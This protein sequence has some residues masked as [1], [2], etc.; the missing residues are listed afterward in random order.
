MNYSKK[1]IIFDAV[2]VIGVFA[3]TLYA[4]FHGQDLSLMLT[5]IRSADLRFL[6][7][8]VICVILF[9]CLESVVMHILLR[10]I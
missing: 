3:L 2:F 1:R 5:H 10:S 8:G 7:P 4:V 6:F 9:I